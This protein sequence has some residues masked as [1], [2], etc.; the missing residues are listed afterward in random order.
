MKQA[1]QSIFGQMAVPTRSSTAV[2]PSPTQIQTT[3]A[4]LT[5][6]IIFVAMLSAFVLLKPLDLT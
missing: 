2:R 5:I 3:E 6:P 4:T 1:S